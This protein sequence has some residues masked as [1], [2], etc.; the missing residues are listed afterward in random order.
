MNKKIGVIAGILAA[1]IVFAGVYKL[2]GS[3]SA[4][5]DPSVITTEEKDYVL[6]NGE[7]NRN[8]TTEPDNTAPDFLVYDGDGN[9]V[10]V[11]DYKGKPVVINFWTSWCGYC[12]QEM[13]H[14]QKAFEENPDIQFL[15]VNVAVS[16]APENS[17]KLINDGGYTFPVVYDKSGEA[18]D[19]YGVSAYP[20][21]YFIDKDGQLVTYSN[22][23]LSEA[24]LE[25]RLK[26]I[27]E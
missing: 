4:E 26:L 20:V 13:P 27:T 9:Q 17:N 25:S 2:Y 6:H 1:I 5:Y 16:D 23:I 11:S 7:D 22:G 24:G 18:I 10:R 15:M 3:L 14:F 19:K 8:Q 21:T 12:K